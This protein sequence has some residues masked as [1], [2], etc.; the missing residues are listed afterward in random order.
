MGPTTTS[1]GQSSTRPSGRKVKPAATSYGPA[2]TCTA[3]VNSKPTQLQGH[4]IQQTSPTPKK[5]Q[6]AYKNN[7]MKGPRGRG[8]K[9]SKAS[10]H[11]VSELAMIRKADAR[12]KA[13]KTKKVMRDDSSGV[14]KLIATLGELDLE[15]GEGKKDGKK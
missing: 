2:S 3:G 12:K 11:H 10:I 5:L 1:K 6:V 13:M 9:A 4:R 14:Q 8:R 15:I 7:A